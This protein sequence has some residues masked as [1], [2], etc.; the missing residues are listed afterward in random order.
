MLLLLFIPC[1]AELFVVNNVED[2]AVAAAAAAVAADDVDVAD[3]VDAVA[4]VDEV[5]TVIMR[6][7]RSMEDDIL[8]SCNA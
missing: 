2:A 3:A 1:V 8:C 6:C 7:R 4:D 5:I